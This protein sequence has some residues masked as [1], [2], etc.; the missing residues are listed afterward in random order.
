MKLLQFIGG[1]VFIFLV[2]SCTS[3][4]E[5]FDETLP[6]GSIKLRFNV[7]N[8][9]DNN[10]SLEIIT[11]KD[12]R[13]PIGAI[14]SEGGDVSVNIRVL[15]A[16]KAE[17][18]TL[19]YSELSNSSQNIDTILNYRIKMVKVTP[20]P[21]LNKPVETDSIYSVFVLVDKI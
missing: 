13:C 7:Q 3:K 10:L 16:E 15:T 19:H 17:T 8:Q 20:L 5:Y 9:V 4:Y 2:F 11:I 1:I 6:E 18:K 12:N 14:C 21:Y